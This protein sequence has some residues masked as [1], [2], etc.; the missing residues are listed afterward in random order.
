MN[1]EWL[2]ALL[3]FWIIYFGGLA[4]LAL[5]RRPARRKLHCRKG[6]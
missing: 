3:V 5:S 1:T 2:P 4:L 6:D